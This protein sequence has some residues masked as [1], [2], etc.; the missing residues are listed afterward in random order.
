MG[1]V[2]PDASVDTFKKPQLCLVGP[3]KSKGSKVRIVDCQ[4]EQ[5]P[6]EVKI[7]PSETSEVSSPLRE[8]T[9][10]S[11][12]AVTSDKQLPEPECKPSKPQRGTSTIPAQKL[13]ET[14][15]PYLEP[16]WGGTPPQ[17]YRLDVIKSGTV[18]E[19]VQLSA[20]SYFVFGR[21]TN[22]DIQ[23]LHPTVSRHHLVLQYSQGTD[24]KPQGFYL[25]DLGSTHGTFLNKTRVR[26][27]MFIRIK[28]SF[29]FM[30]RF[31]SWGQCSLNLICSLF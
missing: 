6:K 30:S 10:E 22:C 31:D 29:I 3:R 26:P 28:V 20:K 11:A 1:E 24:D 16:K 15:I 13:K 21:Q 27:E 9:A 14:P 19:P 18:L 5:K 4:I 8:P 23:M 2:Q 17:E 7:E 25:Y 12:Q